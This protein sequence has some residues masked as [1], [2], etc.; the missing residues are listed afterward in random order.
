MKKSGKSLNPCPSVIQTFYDIV[1]V[2]GGKLTVESK[3]GAGSTF[4]IH[5]PA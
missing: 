2:H 5:L 1:K 3:V 4:I